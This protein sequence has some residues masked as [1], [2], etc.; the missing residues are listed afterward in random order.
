[1]DPI[2]N[3]YTVTLT[4]LLFGGCTERPLRSPE[5]KTLLK[6]LKED[7]SYN[8]E[9]EIFQVISQGE[10]SNVDFLKRFMNR[11]MCLFG[12]SPRQ[13]QKIF[14]APSR[15]DRRNLHYYVMKGCHESENIDGC[16]FFLF[17]FDELNE[18]EAIDYVARF[19]SY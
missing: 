9:Q 15:V 3:I 5:C 1:M 4:L 18:L 11:R 7:W 2:R 10:R 19:R 6:E 17:A 16:Q 13:I 12:S 14:G 8:E